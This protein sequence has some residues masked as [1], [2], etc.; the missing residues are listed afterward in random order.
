MARRTLMTS[1]YAKRVK[2][3]E[4]Y[5]IIRGNRLGGGGKVGKW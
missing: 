5:S 4:V 2:L 1:A 3:A